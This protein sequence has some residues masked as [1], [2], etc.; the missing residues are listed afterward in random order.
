M[1]PVAIETPALAETLQILATDEIVPDFSV[2]PSRLRQM[3]LASVRPMPRYGAHE[4]GAG[5][6]SRKA[7]LGWL[8]EL[9]GAHLVWLTGDRQ[10]PRDRLLRLAELQLFTAE[11][12]EQ[13]AD[14][15]QA[16]GPIWRFDWVTEEFSMRQDAPSEHA[17]KPASG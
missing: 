12:I 1:P 4:V 11:A 2:T 7:L 14:L 10:P 6:F 13:L 8:G 5:F 15:V 9:T 17:V 3:L 16:T